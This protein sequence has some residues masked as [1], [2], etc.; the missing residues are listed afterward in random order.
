LGVV[1]GAWFGAGVV[2]G[3]NVAFLCEMVVGEACVLTPLCEPTVCVN[4][5]YVCIRR[6]GLVCVCVREGGREDDDTKRRERC[7]CRRMGGAYLLLIR[8]TLSPSLR[9][10][11]HLVSVSK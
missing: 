1:N 7:R 8:C 4:G 3:G 6:G 5:I 2:E 9:V 10:S 11:P